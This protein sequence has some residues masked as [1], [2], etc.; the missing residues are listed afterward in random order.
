LSDDK[1]RRELRNVMPDFIRK[2]ICNLKKWE[3]DVEFINGATKHF[4]F[5]E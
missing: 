4:I 1:V 5:D 2:I 3:Y